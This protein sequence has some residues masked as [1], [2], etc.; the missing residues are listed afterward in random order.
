M[1]RLDCSL[2]EKKKKKPP[3]FSPVHWR[4]RAGAG[5]SSD[6]MK[7]GFAPPEVILTGHPHP[8]ADERKPNPPP[9]V[10]RRSQT[11]ASEATR[12]GSGTR[13]PCHRRGVLR[14]FRLQSALL[15]LW[16]GDVRLRKEARG[17]ELQMEHIVRAGKEGGAASDPV[18]CSGFLMDTHSC[19]SK[20]GKAFR[21]RGGG[22]QQQQNKNYPAEAPRSTISF[23]N[24]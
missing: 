1:P 9:G 17:E 24:K 22:K 19:S 6:G 7:Q 5:E 11:K 10:V 2:P 18:G 3:F 12:R 20:H 15:P 4:Q 16:R 14:S 23:T 8:S 13:R 21:T